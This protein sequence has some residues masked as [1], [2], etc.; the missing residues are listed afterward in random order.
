MCA[1]QPPRLV[2]IVSK[3]AP[4]G[5]ESNVLSINLI[6]V[7]GSLG[8]E[9]M[10]KCRNR[11]K[12]DTHDGSAQIQPIW[13]FWYCSDK[14]KFIFRILRQQWTILKSLFSAQIVDNLVKRKV[15]MQQMFVK[16]RKKLSRHLFRFPQA[17]SSM[18]SHTKLGKYPH[19]TGFN[20]FFF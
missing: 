3:A 4:K 13:S 7:A 20:C 2:M 10:E 17:H 18:W 11:Q 5:F 12:K 8:S 16:K 19:S 6:N 9:V 15:N 14:K 1:A